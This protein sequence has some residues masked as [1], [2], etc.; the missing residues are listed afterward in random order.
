MPPLSASTLERFLTVVQNANNPANWKPLVSE[1]VHTINEKK[2]TIQHDDVM[3]F[4][5][6]FMVMVL[7]YLMSFVLVMLTV[8]QLALVPFYELLGVE[9]YQL[10][11]MFASLWA[12]LMRFTGERSL[13]VPISYSEDPDAQCSICFES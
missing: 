3:E 10:S 9:P 8:G 13:V 12:A 4:L 11:P 2:K 6:G 7:C 1:L 5:T